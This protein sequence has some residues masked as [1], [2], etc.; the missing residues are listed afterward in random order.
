MAIPCT[1][2]W[3]PAPPSVA[4]SMGVFEIKRNKADKVTR[5]PRHLLKRKAIHVTTCV[6]TRNKFPLILSSNTRCY[7]SL[8]S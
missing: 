5:L 6:R 4:V 3:L 8:R 2:W 1:L 7:K